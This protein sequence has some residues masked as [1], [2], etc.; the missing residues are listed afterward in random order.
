MDNYYS[1]FIQFLNTYKDQ[2][3]LNI[4]SHAPLATAVEKKLASTGQ[5]LHIANITHMKIVY[6][7]EGCHKFFGV[8]PE[9]VDPGIY[10]ERT[11]PQDIMRHSLGRSKLLRMGNEMFINKKGKLLLS[12]CFKTLNAHGEYR[13]LLY[14]LFICYFNE[15]LPAVY[16]LQINTDVTDLKESTKCDHFYVGD[17]DQLFRYPDKELLCVGLS[18][19]D[20]E[21]E[22]IRLIAQGLDSEQIAERLFLSVHTIN[23]HRRNI[24]DKTGHRSTHELVIEMQEIGML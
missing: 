18:L 8:E 13:E 16:S 12:S 14:Q 7:S 24:L 6:R 20:R 4:D 21:S 1:L 23:T 17:D 19:T 9:E 2:G 22:I 5:F 11:H 3:F 15:P 10:L